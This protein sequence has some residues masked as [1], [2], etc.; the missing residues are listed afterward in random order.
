MKVHSCG[1]GRVAVT[2][3]VADPGEPVAAGLIAALDAYQTALYPTA[4]NHLLAVEALRASNVTFLLATVDGQAVGCGALVDRGEYAEVKRM[5][6]APGFRGRGIAAR[7]LAE[8][9]QHT[10]DLRVPVIRLET[11]VRQPEA[12][13]LYE[14]AG[15]I[16]SGPFGDYP[17]DPESVFMEKQLIGAEG[18]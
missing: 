9:E 5:F 17:D 16:R 8:L 7:L 4:S 2:I 3:E 12:L 1:G 15:Y 13:R 11:G 6:V 10:H 18:L 14:R